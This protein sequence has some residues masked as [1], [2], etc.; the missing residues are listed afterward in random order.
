MFKPNNTSELWIATQPYQ[1]SDDLKQWEQIKFITELKHNYS[2]KKE[3]RNYF[4]NKGKTTS[5]TTG[6]S[7]SLSVTFDYD[8]EQESHKYLLKLLLGDVYHLNNQ[9]IKVK[10]HNFS[11]TKSTGTI[12]ISGKATVNFK[13]HIPSG[14]ADEIVKMQVDFIP[15]DDAWVVKESEE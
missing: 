4:H 1:T 13:N 12:E 7:Q 10:I 6:S 2:V 9:F 15:Q 5:I 3:D 14:N 11:T 8:D